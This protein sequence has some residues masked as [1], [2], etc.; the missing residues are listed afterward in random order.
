MV[1]D[2]NKWLPPQNHRNCIRW[3]AEDLKIDKENSRR[4]RDTGWI[5]YDANWIDWETPTQDYDHDRITF[6]DSI[7]WWIKTD[8]LIQRLWLISYKIDFAFHATYN[9]FDDS[10][11]IDC[12]YKK[13]FI[14]LQIIKIQTVLI[15]NTVSI[16]FWTF[17]VRVNDSSYEVPVRFWGIFKE[18]YGLS[19]SIRLELIYVQ[20][21][22]CSESY[23]HPVL[24]G[25]IDNLFLLYISGSEIR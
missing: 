13:R 2:P 18:E 1:P 19:S 24:M 23:W 9:E 8:W 16:R 17:H 22:E 3:D 14:L 12:S 11:F 25:L 10:L 21:K 5:D 4:H 6:S 15:I 7:L 20:H